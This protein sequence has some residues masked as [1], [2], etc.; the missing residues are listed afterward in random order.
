MSDWKAVP[1]ELEGDMLAE[2]WRAINAHIGGHDHASLKYAWRRTLAAAPPAPTDAP[3]TREEIE[4]LR[5]VLTGNRI[6]A[7]LAGEQ[8][9]ADA[10]TRM[11]DFRYN[12]LCDMALQ[13][14][15][16]PA[17]QAPAQSAVEV[18]GSRCID[19]G[20]CHHECKEKCFRRECCEPLSGYAGPWKYPTPSA[21]SEGE[22]LA[23]ELEQEL[24]NAA[25]W[26]EATGLF[27]PKQRKVSFWRETITALRTGRQA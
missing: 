21:Q 22:R 11:V 17:A 24:A 25:P 12:A 6:K 7:H 13:S 10:I 3:L 5:G 9:I 14:L 16:L 23:D 20:S 4:Q 8:H 18:L 27:Q 19:G 1:S 2:M 26:H 15:A